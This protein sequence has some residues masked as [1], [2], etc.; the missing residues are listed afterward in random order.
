[1][2]RQV[3]FIQGGGDGGYEADKALA[4]SLQNAL[5]KEYVV[6]YPIIN[7]DETAPDFGWVDQ[8]GR[9]IAA[10]KENIILVGHSFGA[11]II[12]KYLSDH[13]VSKKIAGIFLIATPF[14]SDNEKW[15]DGLKLSPTF[16]E[17]LNK[18]VPLFFYHCKD[19]EEVPFSDLT[20]YRE[21][22]SH[23]TIRAI[24]HGGHQLGNDLH[25]VARDIKLIH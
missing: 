8:I 21:K 23:A 7:T 10:A 22:I 18:G 25:A 20:L 3:L 24:S 5:G 9:H 15:K 13:V 6:Y 16:A 2:S 19:D 12:I 11:S 4:V 14:W 17:K 1:M